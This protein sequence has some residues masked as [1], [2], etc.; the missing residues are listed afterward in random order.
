MC[1][2]ALNCRH[3]SKI[4]E[5]SILVLNLDTNGIIS[6]LKKLNTNTERNRIHKNDY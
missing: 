1:R 6:N 2:Q 5:Q 4:L 3:I